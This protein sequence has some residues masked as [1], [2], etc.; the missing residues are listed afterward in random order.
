MGIK[1]NDDDGR[2]K[3]VDRKKNAD[4]IVSINETE[5]ERSLRYCLGLVGRCF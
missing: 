5:E 1:V 3:I 4:S 2:E